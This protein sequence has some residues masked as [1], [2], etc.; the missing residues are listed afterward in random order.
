MFLREDGQ[1]EK[2]KLKDAINTPMIATLIAVIIFV[3]K[4]PMP[5]L[6]EDTVDTVAAATVPLSM[7]CIGLSLG[8]VSLKDAFVHPRLYALSFM[9]LVVAPLVVWFIMHFFVQSRHPSPSSVPIP[10]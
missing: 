5:M 6:I 3:F 9:R 10:L 1:R 7:M 2:F 8:S 4:I